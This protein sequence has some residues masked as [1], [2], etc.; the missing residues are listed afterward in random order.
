MLGNRPV[1]QGPVNRLEH[2]LVG[3]ESGNARGQRRIGLD[4]GG[5][6]LGSLVP[7]ARHR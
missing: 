1:C 5:N 7:P 6:R 3:T 2:L 4:A